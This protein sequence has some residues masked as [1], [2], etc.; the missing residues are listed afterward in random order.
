MN[1][2][3]FNPQTNHKIYNHRCL[4]LSG[5]KKLPWAHVFFFKIKN[6]STLFYRLTILQ[7]FSYPIYRLFFFSFKKLWSLTTFYFFSNIHIFR[8]RQTK[9]YYSVMQSDGNS[10][11][12]DVVSGSFKKTSWDSILDYTKANMFVYV[13]WWF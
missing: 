10:F 7:F 2:R 13:L 4:D 6:K 11:S 1:K 12:G 8:Y 3:S 5:T 9:W